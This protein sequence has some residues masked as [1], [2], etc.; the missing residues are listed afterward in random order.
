[1]SKLTRML[2]RD[3]KKFK[4]QFLAATAVVFVGI[5]LFAATFMSYKNLEN[6]M[7]FYYEKGNFL[8]YYAEAQ[9]ITANEVEQVKRIKGVKNAAGRIST[10]IGADI[11][12]NNRVTLRLVALPDD[13][14]PD[15]NKVFPVSGGYLSP[16][17]QNTCL[18]NKKFA[19]FHNLKKGDTIK[20]VINK[21][22]HEY[23]IHGIDENPEFIFIVRSEASVFPVRG[24]F[25]I[26]YVK[27]ST[28]RNV[29][30]YNDT[31]NQLHVTFQAGV[32][33]NILINQIEKILEPCG[34]SYG[35]KRED[36]LSH[37]LLSDDIEILKEVGFL[38]PVLFLTVAAMIIYVMQKKIIYT[39]R[40]LIGVMKA[41]GYNNGRILR[42]Y[43]K[44]SV[45]IGLFGSIPAIFAGYYLSIAITVL[46][47]EMVR[48]QTLFIQMYWEVVSIGAGFA[49]LFC[50]LAGYNSVKGILKIQP[51]QAMRSEAPIVGRKIFL[52]RIE[53]FWNSLSFGW[54]MSVRN[55]LR[56]RS[57]A[58]FTVLGFVLTIMLFMVSNFF[59]GSVN[60][61]LNKHFFIDQNYDYKLEFSMPAS[62]YD[63]ME[64]RTV[65]GVKKVEPLLEVA[66]DISKGWRKEKVIL[67]GI[68]P[69]YDYFKLTD[70]D[71]NEITSS[72]CT[73][74]RKRAGQGFR[75]YL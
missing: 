37:K 52:E 56:N 15:I 19:E 32:D 30:G 72:C 16:D 7:N 3:I 35:V 9:S 12:D 24:E 8:D 6:S 53:V 70:D 33:Q 22:I 23:I 61:F 1:M 36:H 59:T 51:A 28:A 48:I 11:G 46:Y 71:D 21:H 41:F 13:R 62:Y 54:K 74:C 31:F 2:L 38:F 67:T 57:R 58:L 40:T 73:F 75:K 42:H 63:V 49:L 29:L 18:I 44:V 60:Y 27:E 55:I 69:D 50:I 34:F 39:Q 17:I 5:T 26:I 4:G 43:L 45:L 20:C 47:N 64:L 25:G 14:Q 66:I 68:G 65:D 10:E